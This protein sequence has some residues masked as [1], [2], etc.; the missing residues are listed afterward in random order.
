MRTHPVVRNVRQETSRLL[1]QQLVVPGILHSYRSKPSSGSCLLSECRRV[2]CR[3]DGWKI[4][5]GRTLSLLRWIHI[6]SCMRMYI[7]RAL[8]STYMLHWCLFKH[9]V[10]LVYDIAHIA[11]RRC[12]QAGVAVPLGG[13]NESIPYTPSSMSTGMCYEEVV[14]ARQAKSADYRPRVSYLRHSPRSDNLLG[15]H[16]TSSY[17]LPRVGILIM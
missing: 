17:C 4:S 13:E 9:A 14:R 8:L 12:E 2:E 3:D 7:V 5:G 6:Y 15:V 11:S 1:P 10:C 16:T